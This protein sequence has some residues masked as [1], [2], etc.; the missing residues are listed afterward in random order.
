MTVNYYARVCTLLD[1]L[2]GSIL[3]LVAR[4]GVAAV[5]FMSGRTKVRSAASGTKSRK[6]SSRATQHAG[7]ACVKER[8]TSADRS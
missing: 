8:T 7:C 1:R 3:L 4:F 6:D 5:F 2:P